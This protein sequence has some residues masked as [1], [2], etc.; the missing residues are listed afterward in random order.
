MT[1]AQYFKALQKQLPA[2]ERAIVRDVIQVEAERFHAE[3]FRKEGFTDAGFSPWPPRKK[4]DNNPAKRALL[5]KSGAMR[6]HA[7]KGSVKNKQVD[8]TFPLVYMR[9]HNEGGK[10]GRG[11]GFTMPKRQFVGRSAELENR[12]RRKVLAILNARLK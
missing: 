6:R 5:V 3:N 11:A 2:I 7:T 4:A 12:I 1:P 9:V 8:F 10:A